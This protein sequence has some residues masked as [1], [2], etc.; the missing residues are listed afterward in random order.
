MA[1]I[2]VLTEEMVDAALPVIPD[3]VSENVRIIYETLNNQLSEQFAEVSADETDFLTVDVVGP[4]GDQIEET[5]IRQWI[6]E[7]EQSV[8]GQYFTQTG[9]LQCYDYTGDDQLTWV[10]NFQVLA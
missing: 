5:I 2:G 9:R 3:G 4:N 8:F 6:A 1:Y 7:V 10:I